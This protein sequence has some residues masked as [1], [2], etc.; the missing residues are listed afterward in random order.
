MTKWAVVIFAIGLVFAV[1]GCSSNYVIATK[2]GR[3]ILTEGKPK[4]DDETGLLSY[5]DVEGNETQINRQEVSQI[6]KR[7]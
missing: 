3:I 6:I 2:D 7:R 5:H 1:S 4:G